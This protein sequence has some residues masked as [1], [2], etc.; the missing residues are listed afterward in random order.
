MGLKALTEGIE[1]PKQHPVSYSLRLAFERRMTYLFAGPTGSVKI[2]IYPGPLI[3]VRGG[4]VVL[5]LPWP[6]PFTAGSVFCYL[7]KHCQITTFTIVIKT[8]DPNTVSIIRFTL[9]PL[10]RRKLFEDSFDIP[11]R[12]PILE[13]F[14][15]QIIRQH[16]QYVR[17]VVYIQDQYT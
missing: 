10:K 14:L 9:I 15:I 7:I 11:R 16:C 3:G 6:K 17:P 4:S 5:R 12:M 13:L 2:P 1:P 8:I